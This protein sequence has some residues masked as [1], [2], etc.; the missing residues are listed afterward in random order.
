[1]AVSIKVPFS[2]HV[3]HA[4]SIKKPWKDAEMQKLKRIVLM[5]G[6]T[7]LSGWA[8]A[9]SFPSKPVKFIVPFPPGG[10]AESTARLVAQ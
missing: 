7:L 6:W 4:F 2:R 9:Q 5:M 8:C 10:G 1:M 3:D